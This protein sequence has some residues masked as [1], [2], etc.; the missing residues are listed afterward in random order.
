LEDRG[1]I[2]VKPDDETALYLE[3]CAL[4]LFDT[5]HQIAAFV[6]VLAA[7]GQAVFIGRFDADKHCIETGLY[8]EAHQFWIIRQV[9]GSFRAERHTGFALAPLN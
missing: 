7:F 9:N 4:K 5:L 6:L 1:G 2:I 3:T 8:H